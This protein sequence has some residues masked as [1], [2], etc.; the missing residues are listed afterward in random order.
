MKSGITSELVR[1][2]RLRVE[3]DGLADNRLE[4][5]VHVRG[6]ANGRRDGPRAITR[7][8]DVAL[9]R[10]EHG[11]EQRLARRY[12]GEE[13]RRLVVRYL[14]DDRDEVADALE[15]RRRDV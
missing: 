6:G 8:V 7:H 13:E 11:R 12:G 9:V 1:H 15:T 5:G 14:Q 4:V 2:E 10:A 3:L